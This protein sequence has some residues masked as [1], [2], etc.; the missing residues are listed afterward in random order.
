MTGRGGS[1]DQR[2]GATPPATRSSASYGTPIVALGSAWA[3][4]RSGAGLTCR[5][6]TRSAVRPSRSTSFSV[7]GKL[8]VRSGRPASVPE[9]SSSSPAGSTASQ[10]YGAA[11]PFTA[12]CARYGSPAR[13]T[14]SSLV[15]IESGPAR[16][17]GAA[18]RVALSS[19]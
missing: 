14:G 1:P 13:A 15:T 3:M 8:P 9:A 4:T 10:V 11:P 12:S 17:P 5:T 19:S 6:K 2:S 16:S 7:N 18:A